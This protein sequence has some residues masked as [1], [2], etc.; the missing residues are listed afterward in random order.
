MQLRNWLLL[1]VSVVICACPAV[2]LAKDIHCLNENHSVASSAF[3]GAGSDRQ[4]EAAIQS[5][6]SGP[7]NVRKSL[8]DGAASNADRFRNRSNNRLGARLHRISKNSKDQEQILILGGP[9]AFA[10]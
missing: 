3:A 6:Q 9:E 8:A 2:V 1:G 10:M 5:I 7:T 4:L